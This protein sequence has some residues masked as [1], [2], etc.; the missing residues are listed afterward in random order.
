MLA[1][2]DLSADRKAVKPSGGDG[3]WVDAIDLDL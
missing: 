3:A 1:S 2:A